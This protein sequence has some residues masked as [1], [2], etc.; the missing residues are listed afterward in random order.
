MKKV[1]YLIL[2]SIVAFGAL[3]IIG[4]LAEERKKAPVRL[5]YTKKNRGKLSEVKKV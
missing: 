3:A 4:K 1:K 2:G 5:K